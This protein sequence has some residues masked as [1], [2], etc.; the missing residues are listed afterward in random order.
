MCRE[1]SE[2]LKVNNFYRLNVTNSFV[3]AWKRIYKKDWKSEKKRKAIWVSK[4]F[5]EKARWKYVW[6]NYPSWQ[7]S[8]SF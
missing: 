7:D 5:V 3:L 2:V 4:F 8:L 6:E 1:K